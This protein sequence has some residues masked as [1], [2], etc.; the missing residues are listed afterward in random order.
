M[1]VRNHPMIFRSRLWMPS[2]QSNCPT[3][4]AVSS[5]KSSSWKSYE[6]FYADA[7]RILWKARFLAPKVSVH[8]LLPVLLITNIKLTTTILLLS[9]LPSQQIILFLKLTFPRIFEIWTRWMLKLDPFILIYLTTAHLCRFHLMF[10]IMLMEVWRIIVIFLI[11]MMVACIDWHIS[12]FQICWRLP[13]MI[14]TILS[15]GFIIGM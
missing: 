2:R 15:V 8:I 9:L 7:D 5:C 14:R 1:F 13:K 10:N 11:L 3:T 12:L 4:Q 6:I